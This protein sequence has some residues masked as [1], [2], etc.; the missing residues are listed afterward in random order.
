MVQKPRS[1]VFKGTSASL[2]GQKGTLVLTSLGIVF[3]Y[4][5]GKDPLFIPLEKIHA[6]SIE[7]RIMKKLCIVED[8]GKRTYFSVPQ[9]DEWRTVLEMTIRIFEGLNHSNSPKRQQQTSQQS[10]TGPPNPQPSPAP[11]PRN[12]KSAAQTVVNQS[13]QQA[14]STITVAQTAPS[15]PS[16]PV[17]AVY[18]GQWP[19]GQDYE[20]AFQ[21]IKLSINPAL[22][23]VDKWDAV[24]NPKNPSWYVHASGNYGSIYKIKGEDGK[25]YAVKCFTKKSL[26]LNQRYSRISDYLNGTLNGSRFLLHFSYFPEGIRTRKVPNVY[27]PLLKMGWVDGMT[28]NQFISINLSRAKALRETGNGIMKAIDR[29]QVSGVAHGDLS[30]DNIIVENPGDVHLVD[31]DGMFIPS[32]KGERATELGHADFQH[33]KRTADTYSEKLDSF[34]AL[35]IQL[36]LQTI[37]VKP[38]YW[39]KFNGN[40]PD[41]LILRKSDFLKPDKSEAF[42]AIKGIRN[43]KIRNL[44]EKLEDYLVHGPLWDGFKPS[45]LII[46]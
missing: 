32:F 44:C 24:R 16:K 43:R 30:G 10:V 18:N 42:S 23:K 5:T 29:L 33:P 39:K 12:Q 2:N 20:H 46:S 36:S 31:Y 11:P 38:E 7:G 34:S 8:S 45:D 41:C 27:F 14:Q 26:T 22:G 6:T 25:Y 35:V 40:D 1:Y 21:T 37:A 28:L 19:S 17:P 9:L 3:T 15:P 13:V 4:D